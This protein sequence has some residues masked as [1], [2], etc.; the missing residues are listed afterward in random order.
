MSQNIRTTPADTSP[1]HDHVEWCR[2][3]DNIGPLDQQCRTEPSELYSLRGTEC[4]PGRVSVFAV[5]MADRGAE[6]PTWNLYAAQ[7][8]LGVTTIDGHQDV[9]LTPGEIRRVAAMLLDA[10]DLADSDA[11]RC[12]R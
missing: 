8:V 10:A 2:Q 9:A 3:H 5:Q 11:V 4:D 12:P 7:V 6:D 1:P